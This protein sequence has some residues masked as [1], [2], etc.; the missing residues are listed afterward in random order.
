MD[1]V[2]L[3]QEFVEQFQVIYYFSENTD[4]NYT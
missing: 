2:E 1:T 3:S 4:Y